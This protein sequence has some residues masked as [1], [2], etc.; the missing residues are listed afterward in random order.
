MFTP[1]TIK[2]LTA[3]DRATYEWQMWSAGVGEAGQEK[4]KNATVLISRTGGVG[5]VVAYELAAA[6]VGKLV[7]IHGGVVRPSDL[8]RQLLMTHQSLGS[9]RIESVRA[10]LLDL[11]PELEIVGLGEHADQDN[12]FPLAE[13][14][15][16]D[17]IVDCAPMFAERFA[18]SDA[19]LR[20]KKPMVE[21]GMYDMEAQLTTFLPGQTPC[22][23]CLFPEP[24]STW[25]RQFPVFGAVAGSIGAMAATEVIKLIAGVGQPL[26][27]RWL[28]CDFREMRFR[29][30]QI[31]RR[32]DCPFCGDLVPDSHP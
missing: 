29:T 24:P 3:A 32:N 7:I 8:N 28:H 21:C 11:N 30:L 15:N 4:L 2:P 31:D 20:L 9:P 16:V 10:R 27:G 17:V 5:S 6:G 12:V 14:E 1:T 18:L 23:R 19:S 13:Q 22:L 25:K 26:F